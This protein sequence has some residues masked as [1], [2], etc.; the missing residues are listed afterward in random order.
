MTQVREES[1]SRTS[2][3]ETVSVACPSDTR[4]IGG[5]WQ[6]FGDQEGIVVEVNRPSLGGTE[7]VASVSDDR[8]GEWSLEVVA[9][10]AE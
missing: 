6:V 4:L 1:D 9:L 5:G 7:W 8:V 3:G 10:C 2:G